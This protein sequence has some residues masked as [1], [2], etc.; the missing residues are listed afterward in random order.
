[1]IPNITRIGKML[2]KKPAY[3]GDC[4]KGFFATPRDFFPYGKGIYFLPEMGYI[5]DA[6]GYIAD[7]M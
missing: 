6:M 2:R 1:M 5:A 7:A 4:E 3:K